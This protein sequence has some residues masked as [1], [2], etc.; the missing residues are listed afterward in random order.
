MVTYVVDGDTFDVK[1]ENG[2]TERIRPILV[3][4]PEI[5]HKSSPSDCEAE[6]YGD[7]AADFTKDL[8]E[9]ETV[10]LEQD[11]SERDP[12]DRLLAYVYLENGQMYQELILSE[13]L[14]EVSVYEPDIK[15]QSHLEKIEQ[16]INKSTTHH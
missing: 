5:C 8:L 7:E 16:K 12:Y 11:V 9:G 13:G 6:P 3:N 4:A 15:Y 10:Y 14:A 1:L 2:K